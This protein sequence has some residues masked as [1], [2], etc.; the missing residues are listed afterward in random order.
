MATAIRTGRRGMHVN[1]L[2]L[3]AES[4]GIAAGLLLAALALLGISV[5]LLTGPG[6]TASVLL[7]V[8]LLL[9]PLLGAGALCGW[10]V[11]LA[12]KAGRRGVRSR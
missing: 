8:L 4:Q 10:L 11:A 1:P 2:R 5:Y 9:L 12:I 6:A 7:P 3:S